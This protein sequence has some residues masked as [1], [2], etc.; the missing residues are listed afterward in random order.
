MLKYQF[1]GL[2]A[3]HTSFAASFSCFLNTRSCMQ[4]LVSLRLATAKFCALTQTSM[5]NELQKSGMLFSW[6]YNGL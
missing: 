1:M 5:D 6:A 2:W 4:L 3:W